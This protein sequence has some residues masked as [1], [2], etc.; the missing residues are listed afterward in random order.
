MSKY[1]FGKSHRLKSKQQIDQL[2]V[3]GNS[4][5]EFPLRVVWRCTEATESSVQIAFSI[6]KKNLPKAV[7]RNHVK[8]LIRESYRQQ[9]KELKS[10]AAEKG[11]QLQIMLIFLDT[12]L[13]DFPDLDNKISVTL[14]RLQKEL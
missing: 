6:S 9:N 7:H 2:F 13:W 4:F 3:E 12:Q 10:M 1:T 8:R 11:K 5:I 14:E